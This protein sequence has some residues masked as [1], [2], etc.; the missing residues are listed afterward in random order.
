MATWLT[1]LIV[2]RKFGEALWRQS[3]LMIDA[4]RSV[5]WDRYAAV[6]SPAWAVAR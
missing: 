5:A 1:D 4:M 3:T 6:P 2:A